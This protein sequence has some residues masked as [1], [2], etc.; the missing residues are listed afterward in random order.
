MGAI[1]ALLDRRARVRAREIA[2]DVKFIELAHEPNFQM[3]FVRATQ[4]PVLD[5]SGWPRTENP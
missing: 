5:A 2:R 4:F 3:R 1:M